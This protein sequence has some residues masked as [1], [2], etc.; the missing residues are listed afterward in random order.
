M[1]DLTVMAILF[2]ELH[3]GLVDL[4][5]SHESPLDGYCILKLQGEE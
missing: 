5:K 3:G 2:L 4:K 1:E